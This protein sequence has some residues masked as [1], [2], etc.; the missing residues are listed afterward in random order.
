MSESTLHK[1]KNKNTTKTL[2][3]AFNVSSSPPFQGTADIP[4]RHVIK[5]MFLFCN[6]LF[7]MKMLLD[8]ASSRFFLPLPD[9]NSFPP[10]HPIKQLPFLLP[11]VFPS[12]SAPMED[13]LTLLL[14][15]LCRSSPLLGL[16]FYSHSC[17][18]CVIDSFFPP[19]PFHLQL[20]H[21]RVHSLCCV[22]LPLR[23]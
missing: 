20:T 12:L 7:C 6:V 5:G 21:S 18:S 17:C 8:F 22:N 1:N 2:F 13:N 23:W 9:R 14:Q 3:C 16:L 10:H 19:M 15:T 11:L 4:L